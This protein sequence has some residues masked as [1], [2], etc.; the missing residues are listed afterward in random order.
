M[1]SQSVRGGLSPFPLSGPR[2][3]TP[4]VSLGSSE[5]SSQ[6]EE[7]VGTVYQGREDVPR[8]SPS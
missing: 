8:A 1:R 7:E 4:C 5:P 2:K 6:R 3:G